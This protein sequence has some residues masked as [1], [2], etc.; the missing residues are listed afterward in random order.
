MNPSRRALMQHTLASL[1]LPALGCGREIEAGDL[2][3][4]GPD[5]FEGGTFLD[6]VDFEDEPPP[7]FGS[8]RGAGWDARRRYDLAR[9][10]VD[11]RITPTD[12]FYVRTAEP[13]LVDIQEDGWTIAVGGQAVKPR[14]WT[15]ASILDRAVDQG[16]VLLECSGNTESSN[17]GLMSSATWRGAPLAGLLDELVDVDPAATRVLVSGLDAHSR[18]STHSDPGASWVF[19]LE[20]VAAYGGF[21]AT[22][23]NGERLPRDNGFPVRLVMPRWYGCTCIKWVDEI[24]LVGDDEPATAQMLEFASRT[25]QDGQ[26]KLARD[27]RPAVMQLAAMPVR[28]ERWLVDDRESYRILGIA[29][30]GEEAAVEGLQAELNGVREPVSRCAA[31]DSADT[32]AL[33]V[34]RYDP[35]ERGLVEISMHAAESVPQYRLDRGWYTRTFR[36]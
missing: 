22:H 9:V 18:P 17:F 35:P 14:S 20:E 2:V 23:L 29:W 31:R 16:E 3:C 7:R 10:D 1:T 30:G 12:R 27:Y 4:D 24:R 19:T 11:D 36:V 25:H 34:H 21:L 26:P 15:I 13:D 33:W 32:W 8:L 6:V 28:V 5:P